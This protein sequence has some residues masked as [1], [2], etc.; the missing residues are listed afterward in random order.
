MTIKKTNSNIGLEACKSVPI[1][2]PVAAFGSHRQL[3]AI[4]AEVILD[5]IAS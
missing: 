1:L 3:P 2:F 4:L 5:P